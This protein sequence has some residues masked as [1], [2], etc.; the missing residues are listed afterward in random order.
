MNI[1]EQFPYII[2]HN[3][4]STPIYNTLTDESLETNC[5]NEMIALLIIVEA[6]N[7]DEREKMNNLSLGFSEK[8]L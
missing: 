6:T 7:K 2:V 5:E 3:F 8:A 1:I 4:S